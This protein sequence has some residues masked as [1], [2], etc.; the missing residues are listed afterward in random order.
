[1]LVA[2]KRDGLLLCLHRDWD[3][4]LEEEA[5]LHRLRCPLMAPEGVRIGLLAADVV[6]LSDVFSGD[7]HVRVVKGIPEPV[8]D[9]LVEQIC[10]GHAHAIAIAGLG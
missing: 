4:L 3:N 5:A 10:L 8:V 1:M 6:A 7:A 2:R 9:H